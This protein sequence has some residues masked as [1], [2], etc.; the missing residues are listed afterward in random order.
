MAR[1][2]GLGAGGH[3]R[4]VIDAL[5]LMGGCELA[6]LL[7]ADRTLWG[8]EV[9]GI[10]VLGG[11]DLLPQLRAQGVYHAF[12]GV[13]TT[14]T[15]VPRRRLYEEVRRQGFEVV[16][17]IHPHAVISPSVHLGE[18][19]TVLAAAVINAAA[20]LGDDVIVN[21]GAIVEHEC[22]LGHHVHIATGAR[23]GGGV[24]V[25]D[26]TH[27]GLGASVRQGVRIGHDAIV[28]AGA[29]VVSDV[30]DRVVVAGVPARVVRA[31]EPV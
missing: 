25:G 5:R 10:P 2:I 30:S 19:P 6:G 17:I 11:D 18:G 7:D 26:G 29:A 12:I 31:A 3:A 14:G 20:R 16:R 15:T 9:L 27:I 23:L 1:V 13:G 8:T 28:G 22:V 4:V 21:T 24:T